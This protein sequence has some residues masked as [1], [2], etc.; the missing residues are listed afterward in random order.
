[1]GTVSQ[2][3]PTHQNSFDKHSYLL[4]HGLKAD[5]KPDPDAKGVGE[6]GSME[7]FFSETGSGKYV[8][9]SIFVD[10]DP[11]P[12]DEIRTGQYRQLF[13]PELLISGKED[14]AN[15]CTISDAEAS[16]LM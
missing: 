13:H 9:R 16:L 12:V 14:A 10:L 11:S 15:N 8:P 4:E 7:T 6:S 1:L 5:G 3:F 2:S